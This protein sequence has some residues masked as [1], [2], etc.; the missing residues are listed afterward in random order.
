ML[1][2]AIDKT[3]AI[4]HANR[5]KHNR[6]TV[7]FWGHRFESKTAVKYF[8]VTIDPRLHFKEHAELA[9]KRASDT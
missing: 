7:K 2:L 8:G 3:E 9:A 4:L 6:M 5:N 1:E